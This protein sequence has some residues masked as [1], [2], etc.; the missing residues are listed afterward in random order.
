MTT[1]T[2]TTDDEL[3]AEA[4]RGAVDARAAAPPWPQVGC[5]IVADG[6]VVGRGATGPHP[7]GPHAEVAALRDAGDRARGATAYTTLEPCDHD[8]NTPPCTRA[9]VDAGIARV[10]IAVLDPDAKVAGRGLARLRAAGIEVDVGPGRAVV[11]EYLRAYLHQ[12]R[13]GRAFALLK[14]AMSLDGRTAAADGTS[15]WITGEAA[16]EDVHRLRARSHAIVVGPATAI[17]DRPSLTARNVELGPWG[18]PRRVLIDAS[19]RV[20]VDG[21]L[22]DGSLAPTTVYTTDRMPA[23]T[24]AA[25]SDAGADVRVIAAGP[26]GRGVDLDAVL[27]G[28]AVEYHAFQA[29]VEGG[30]KLHG[31]FVA[32]GRADRLV[33]Y[34]APVILGER[35]RAALAHPGPDTLADARRWRTVDVASVGPDVRITYEPIREVA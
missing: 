35:G 33:T 29:L 17:A 8:G 2:T 19:G 5:V 11:G 7:V 21:P 18:Q 27:H 32:E 22:A 20:P 1:T 6:E 12:R 26:E 15:Q 16:R 3:M 23:A 9:L 30:G 13:T 25:W 4:H 34:V 31:A 24:A 10:V 28:L 14:T